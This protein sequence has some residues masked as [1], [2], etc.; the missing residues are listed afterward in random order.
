MSLRL[1]SSKLCCVDDVVDVVVLNLS[2]SCADRASC[3]KK[4]YHVLNLTV[5]SSFISLHDRPTNAARPKCSRSKQPATTQS[6]SVITTTK[7]ALALLLLLS[8]TIF[9]YP[10]VH[11][12]DTTKVN[13]SRKDLIKEL[14][15]AIITCG[16]FY[17]IGFLVLLGYR[18]QTKLYYRNQL[19]KHQAHQESLKENKNIKTIIQQVVKPNPYIKYENEITQLTNDFTQ[20]K[21]SVAQ[22]L[23]K[24]DTYLSTLESISE[25]KTSLW[26]SDL[27]SNN[28]KG[29]RC[30]CQ[31]YFRNESI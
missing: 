24:V 15:K 1:L 19:L 28:K 31:Y 2:P 9:Y 22:Q 13:I 16:M 12:D 6:I 11:H 25:Q 20:T 7:I 4:I 8:S 27:S 14:R 23:T 18:Y 3:L 21:H 30:C 5:V 29:G 26:T 10:T 17:L